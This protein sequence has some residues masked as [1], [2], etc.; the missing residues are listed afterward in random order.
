MNKRKVQKLEFYIT[1]V[2]NLNCNNCNRFNNH[3]FR[4]WQRWSDFE[5]DYMEWGRKLDVSG[6]VILG[7]EPLLNPTILEWVKGLNQAFGQ[8]V[9]IL[10]NGTRLNHVKGLY[11]TLI[12]FYG[13]TQN[14]IGISVHNSDDLDLY[15]D[16]A[17]KF[18]SG[19]LRTFHGPDCRMPDGHLISY[20]ADYTFVDENGVAV[21]IWVQDSFY[22]ASV[23]RMPPEW[24]DGKLVPGKLT[25]WNNDPEK[26]HE[27]CGFV[28][29]K[30]Y[31]MINARLHKCG[32]CVLMAEFDKQ[33]PLD[34]SDEDRLIL[35]SYRPLSVWDYDEK[36]DDFFAKIDDVL[37]QCKFCPVL[38]QMQNQQIFATL[39]KPGSVSTFA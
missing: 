22:S 38:E 4:G 27:A 19:P 33:H 34:I 1:N 28:Q 8:G 17:K 21:R 29:W 12:D 18:L 26:A 14:W 3:D 20:G 25:L 31:H 39:K 24:I 5:Q 32:P 10:T 6:L 16:E 2:C 11:E 9:Q 36:G 23:R 7:G 15:F 35:N 37:P 30:N 13:P